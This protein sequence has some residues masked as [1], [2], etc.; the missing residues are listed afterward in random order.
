ML[1]KQ[2]LAT[3]DYYFN[4][5]DDDILLGFRKRAGQPAPGNELPGLYAQKR[6][7]PTWAVA[8]RDVA[9]V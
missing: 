5:P 4:L 8:E 3:R 9:H 6:R 1:K 7:Q 2:Y